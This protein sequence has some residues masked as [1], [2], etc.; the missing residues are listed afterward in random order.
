MDDAARV[1]GCSYLGAFFRVILPVSVPGISAATVIAALT[2]WNH[3]LFA[4]ILAPGKAKTMP[5]AIA[6]LITDRV[7]NWG[8]MASGAVICLIPIVALT[9]IL[10]KFLVRGMTLGAVKG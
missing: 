9:V 3:Y 4:L 10:Q 6:S 7:I 1:D 2:A 8:V 5:V